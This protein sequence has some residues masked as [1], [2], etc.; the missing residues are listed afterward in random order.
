LEWIKAELSRADRYPSRF[1]FGPSVVV[2]S[3][4]NP[5]DIVGSND[6]PPANVEPPA[7]LAAL[8]VQSR[9]PTN[10]QPT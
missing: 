8:V 7:M 6:T 5:L 10:V 1:F 2:S 9:D 3:R 4:S